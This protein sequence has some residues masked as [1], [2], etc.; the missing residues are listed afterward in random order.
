MAVVM[1]AVAQVYPLC[2][3]HCIVELFM[4]ALWLDNTT[5]C[6]FFIGPMRINLLMAMEVSDNELLSETVLKGSQMYL[7]AKFFPILVAAAKKT[8]RKKK[9]CP[10]LK[11]L[12]EVP[13]DICRNNGINLMVAETR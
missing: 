10:S 3:H 6:L 9:H 12:S 2:S 5:P 13:T 1:F 8:T 11:N 7:D 4:C